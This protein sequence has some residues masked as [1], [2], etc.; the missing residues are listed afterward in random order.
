MIDVQSDIGTVISVKDQWEL[1]RWLDAQDD[2][3]GVP[4]R[5]SGAELDVHPFF[6]QKMD[7]EVADGIL[8]E[9]GQ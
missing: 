2:E 1:V 4:I 8:T 6:L 3:A 7:N 9:S 5:F